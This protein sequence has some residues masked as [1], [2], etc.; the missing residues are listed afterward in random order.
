[1]VQSGRAR[2]HSIVTHWLFWV[3]FV[4]GIA[5]IIRSIPAWTHV[6]WGCDFGIY[7]G[8]TN[9]FVE[10]KELFN[11]YSGW[12]MSYQYF[13]VLYVITGVAHWITGL[14]VLTVM[15]KLAQPGRG[16]GV[17]NV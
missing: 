11:A 15:P 2:F 17:S 12:G 7:Y 6:A 9:S 3:G 4:T 1:M 5:I 16:V 14:D 10:S 13:P 8:L